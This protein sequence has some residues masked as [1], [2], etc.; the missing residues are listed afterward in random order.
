MMRWMRALLVMGCWTAMGWYPVEA[1]D[2]P[3]AKS[4]TKAGSSLDIRQTQPCTGED[5][6]GNW[7]LVRFESSYRFKNPQAPYLYPHQVFQYSSQGGRCKRRPVA[8]RL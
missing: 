4:L 8:I 1:T 2:H 7:E 6:L 5:V 3:T